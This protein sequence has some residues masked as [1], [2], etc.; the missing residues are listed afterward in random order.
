MFALVSIVLCSFILNAAD[1]SRSWACDVLCGGGGEFGGGSR[2][3]G[4]VNDGGA[5]LLPNWVGSPLVHGRSYG[6]PLL[7]N[8]EGTPLVQGRSYGTPL[9]PNWEGTPL[10]YG[11]SSGRKPTH[12]RFPRF[13]ETYPGQYGKF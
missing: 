13:R 3:P 1:G 12:I 6:T 5:T 9:L 7:P 10:I 2:P 8:W 4:A 11:R